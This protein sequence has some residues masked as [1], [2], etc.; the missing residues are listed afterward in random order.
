[1]WW[2]GEQ[3][4]MEIHQ[5]TGYSILCAV[6][7]RIM[8]GFIGSEG[9][10]FVSFIVAPKEIFRY[11]KQGRHPAG[12]N[13]LGGLSVVAFLL[14]LLS[15]AVSGLF[16]SDDLLFD[17]PL[18]YWAGSTSGA[19]TEWHEINWDLLRVWI[20]VHLLAIAWHQLWK[21]QPLVEAMWMGRAGSK[22]ARTPPKPIVWAVWSLVLS[23]GVLSILLYFAPQPPS[24]Y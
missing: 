22:F 8:W 19:I 17:G 24:Y 6:S 10:R 11:V 18:S 2:S 3:G 1:M 13:P 16:S 15:Q 23:A 20:V 4:R 12:H 5:W 14:L 7:A 21:K 9:A